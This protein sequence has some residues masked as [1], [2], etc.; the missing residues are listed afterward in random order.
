MTDQLT[1]D[2]VKPFIDDLARISLRHGVAISPGGMAGRDQA[3][4]HGLRPD[5]GGY[6]AKP[7][8]G[9]LLETFAAGD[10]PSSVGGPVSIDITQLSNHERIQ[11]LGNR[12]PDLALMLRD[13][14]LAGVE[15]TRGAYV[16]PFEW[17]AD[18][19]AAKIM[20]GEG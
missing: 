13:A 10:P 4:V 3:T 6:A 1:P 11:L 17:D 5:F 20:G 7:F 18:A 14:Y 15:A 8:E 16:G 12:S 19:Y 9:A 2:R